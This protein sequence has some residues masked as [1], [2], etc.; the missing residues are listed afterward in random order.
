[1]LTSNDKLR[2]R[3]FSVCRGESHRTEP[4]RMCAV[5]LNSGNY[6]IDV[7][8][9]EK[10]SGKSINE[11]IRKTFTQDFCERFSMVRKNQWGVK[12]VNEEKISVWR[13][14]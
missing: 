7:A 13:V 3:P 11:V 6:P 2:V 4:S 10:Q 9:L 5:I 8:K 1:M 14:L 12:S